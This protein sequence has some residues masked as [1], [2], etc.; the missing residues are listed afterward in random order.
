MNI[1]YMSYNYSNYNCN[2]ISNTSNNGISFNG[3]K[4]YKDHLTDYELEC[5]NNYANSL[6]EDKLPQ[7]IMFGP[8]FETVNKVM[9]SGNS[10]NSIPEFMQSALRSEFNVNNKTILKAKYYSALCAEKYPKENYSKE[11]DK[12]LSQI[13][14]SESAVLNNMAS[15]PLWSY[16]NI[17]QQQV[18]WMSVNQAIVRE[19][20]EREKTVD[21]KLKNLDDKF[22]KEYLDLREQIRTERQ[23]RMDD[24]EKVKKMLSYMS[25]PPKLLGGSRSWNPP[26]S[27][28]D[29]GICGVDLKDPWFRDE[30]FM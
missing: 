28:G 8:T 2:K 25:A 24:I 3:S 10:Y 7:N 5:L 16:A 13:E 11:V 17:V 12:A 6:K 30:D 18:N 14:K 23:E 21:L 29:G 27:C 26:G 1:K 22:T 15:N 19:C 9:K 4:L 20:D